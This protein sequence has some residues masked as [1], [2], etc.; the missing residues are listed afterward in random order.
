MLKGLSRGQVL[1]FF[2]AEPLLNLPGISGKPFLVK[3]QKKMTVHIIAC[4]CFP[5]WRRVLIGKAHLDPTV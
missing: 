1:A 3:F 2:Q 5:V 4:S